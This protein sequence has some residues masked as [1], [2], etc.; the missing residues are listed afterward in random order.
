MVVRGDDVLLLGDE[1]LLD[2][3]RERLFEGV[4]V[5]LLGY[6]FTL[7]GDGED[8]VV[9]L[10]DAELYVAPGAMESAGDG[11]GLLH[12]V[13]ASVVEFGLEFA[14]EA[15]ALEGFSY[16]E[17]LEVRVLEMLGEIGKALLA[18][19]EGVDD[20]LEDFDY[21]FIVDRF[22]HDVFPS[23]LLSCGAGSVGCGPFSVTGGKRRK[24]RK[25]VP[26]RDA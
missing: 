8:F 3:E 15:G 22:S 18:V 11:A 7:F 26:L 19:F 9:A 5:G 6:V 4:G 13:D 14:A 10:D 12:V 20:V 25:P 21:F 24:W 2:W 16:K 17:L 1:E 23:E